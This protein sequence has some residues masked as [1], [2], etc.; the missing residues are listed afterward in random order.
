MFI[1]LLK[2][3]NESI[4]KIG[5]TKKLKKRKLQL[6][7]GNPFEIELLDFYE[8]EYARKIEKFLHIKYGHTKLTEGFDKLTGEWFVLNEKNV[9]LFKDECAKIEMGCKMLKEVD[10]PFI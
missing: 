9:L 4:Y 3:K 10:N 7:T 8:S 2:V 6:Q 1:Y 5:V